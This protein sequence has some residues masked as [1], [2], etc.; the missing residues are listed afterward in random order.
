LAADRDEVVREMR[1][2]TE[3][4]RGR[5]DGA[6]SEINNRLLKGEDLETQVASLHQSLA[7]LQT[8]SRSVE[9]YA[10]SVSDQLQEVLNSRIWKTLVSIGGLALKLRGR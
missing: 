10:R 8:Q 7:A 9:T 3:N 4:L 2:L 6:L 5:Y 1:A